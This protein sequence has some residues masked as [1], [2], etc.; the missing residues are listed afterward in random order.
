M[1]LIDEEIRSTARGKSAAVGGPIAPVEDGDSITI[2]AE[3]RLL[4]PN[5]PPQELDR[6][7][8]AWKPP[9]ARYT[10][11]VLAKYER[12]VSSSI[13]AVTDCWGE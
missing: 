7:R 2:D 12:L 8:H 3:A 10:A 13:R 9:E 6:R 1:N 4:Q 11:G 5:V